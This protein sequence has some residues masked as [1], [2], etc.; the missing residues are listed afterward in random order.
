MR[1]ERIFTH[2]AVR[3][4]RLAL[5]ILVLALIAIPAWNFYARRVQKND[6]T[7]FGSRLPSGVSVKTEGFTL[8]QTEGGRTQFTV[9]AKQTLAFKDDKYLLQNVD[10]TIYRVKES[11]PDR[12]IRGRNCT[13]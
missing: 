13:Y 10:V 7:K 2:R 6:S 3:L 1:L 5:P 9:H 11:D 12:H 4:L 8:S